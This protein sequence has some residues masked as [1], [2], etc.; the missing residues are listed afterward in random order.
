VSFGAGVRNRRRVSEVEQRTNMMIILGTVTVL[1]FGVLFCLFI[2]WLIF[3]LGKV[4]VKHPDAFGS[5]FAIRLVTLG[6]TA[7]LFPQ[8]VITPFDAVSAFARPFL[9]KLPATLSGLAM[10]RSSGDIAALSNFF[11]QLAAVFVSALTGTLDAVE[12]PK[13][14]FA[15]ALWVVLGSVLG[16]LLQC[17]PASSLCSSAC[18]RGSGTFSPGFDPTGVDGIYR[19]LRHADLA[20]RCVGVSEALRCNATAQRLDPPPA[21]R[22]AVTP[23]RIGSRLELGDAGAPDACLN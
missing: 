21:G 19:R 14:I 1:L 8:A 11:P 18:F 2:R 13:L 9:E 23:E 7:W 4:L 12:V 5:T 17:G 3:K 15:L 10:Y 6:V 22:Y 20:A 16:A